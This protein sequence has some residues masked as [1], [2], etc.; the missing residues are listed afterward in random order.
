MLNKRAEHELLIEELNQ[1][2]TDLQFNHW[3]TL[4]Y[5]EHM[6]LG[7][8]YEQLS[9]ILDSIVESLIGAKGKIKSI[10]IISPSA[11]TDKMPEAIFQCANNL[12]DYSTVNK[13]NDLINISDEITAVGT[14]LQYL[15]RLS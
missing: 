11:P 1:L 10:K 5:A 8:A 6:A 9:E 13:L 2:S 12:R 7:G 4:S 3:N 15:L 14:K